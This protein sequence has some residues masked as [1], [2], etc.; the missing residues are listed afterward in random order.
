MDDRLSMPG[1]FC[2][3]WNMTGD[4]RKDGVKIC[5]RIGGGS[6]SGTL[7]MLRAAST[8]DK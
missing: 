1:S 2:S 4:V 8:G 6:E 3:V 7:Y 5:E